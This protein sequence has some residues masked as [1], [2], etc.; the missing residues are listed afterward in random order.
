MAR[1]L[2]D[3]PYIFGMHDPGGEQHM[4]Q[5]G[6]PGWIVFT[7]AIGSEA[8]DRSGKDFSPW[9]NQGLGILCRLNNGYEPAGTIPH[10]SRYEQFAQRCANYVAA[11]RGC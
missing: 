7:E 2:F 4:I 9:S 1:P 10:S 6:K 11:S 5:S 8:N 3:S